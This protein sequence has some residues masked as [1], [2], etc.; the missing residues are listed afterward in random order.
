MIEKSNLTIQKKAALYWLPETNMTPENRPFAPKGKDR[1]PTIHFRVLSSFQGGYF[2]GR[3]QHVIGC[4]HKVPDREEAS[5]WWQTQPRINQGLLDLSK[6]KN[7]A[8][9]STSYRK[10]VFQPAFFTGYGKLREGNH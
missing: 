4:F 10:V 1:I 6:Q 2:L 3:I 5:G 9:V 7:A 8:S